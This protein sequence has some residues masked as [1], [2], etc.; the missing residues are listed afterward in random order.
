MFGIWQPTDR[1]K[2]QVGAVDRILY[3]A[4]ARRQRIMKIFNAESKC[5]VYTMNCEVGF[6]VLPVS[7]VRQL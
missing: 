6:R 1:L 4:S 2:G 7:D 5:V 3:C